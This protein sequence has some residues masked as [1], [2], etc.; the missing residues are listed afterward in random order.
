[1]NAKDGLLLLTAITITFA[2]TA[3]AQIQRPG[4]GPTDPN[5]VNQDLETRQQIQLMD[6]QRRREELQQ[7]GQHGSG[8]ASVQ[9]PAVVQVQVATFMKA[10]SH[11]RHRFADF[12]QVVI[13]SKTPMTPQMLGLMAES[14]YAADIAY[15]LCKHPET[16][17]AIAIM[18]PAEAGLAIRQ[19]E[20]TLSLQNPKPK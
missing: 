9:D 20:T 18:R 19:L 5:R 6:D 15:Y 17:G 8:G 14:A 4:V 13:Q 1:M 7:P 12:D 10:I 3:H 2:G 11:R 16:S